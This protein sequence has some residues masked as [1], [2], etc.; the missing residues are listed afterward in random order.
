MFKNVLIF[1]ISLC[2][3]LGMNFY[4]ENKTQDTP[5]ILFD[6]SAGDIKIEG[7]SIPENSNKFY[8]SFIEELTNY[9]QS[10]LDKTTVSFRLDYFNTSSSK[11][12]LEIL[13]ILKS[14]TVSGKQVEIN[15]FYDEYDEEIEES[16]ADFSSIVQ[17]PFNSKIIPAN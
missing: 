17:M 5:E 12:I 13:R 16:G 10:P 14:I 4:K 8:S 6:K 2:K 1:L 3:K 9:S 7:R 15:W 11:S